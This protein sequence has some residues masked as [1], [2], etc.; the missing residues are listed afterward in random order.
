MKYIYVLLIFLFISSCSL[1]I[2][3]GDKNLGKGY[4]LF[5]NGNFTCIVKS[6][7]KT[8]KGGGLEIIPYQVTKYEFNKYY[9]IAISVE[10]KTNVRSFW[11]IN[12][13]IPINLN[14]CRESANF[15]K[16]L[17]SNVIGPID[18]ITFYKILYKENIKLKFDN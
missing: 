12:K 15:D 2:L 18:S 3:L 4:F 6:F 17:K 7:K 16:A 14:I 9:I 5:E 8:Y 11:I 1:S 13:K 10:P